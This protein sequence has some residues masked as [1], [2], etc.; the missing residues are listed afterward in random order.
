MLAVNERNPRMNEL[1]QMAGVGIRLFV[2]KF[3]DGVIVSSPFMS[4]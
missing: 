2:N 1:G 3:V 4:F